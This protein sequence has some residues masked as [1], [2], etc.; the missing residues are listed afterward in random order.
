MKIVVC[1]FSCENRCLRFFIWKSLFAM[2]I[3]VC[4]F[5]CENRCLRFFIWKSLFAISHKT[6]FCEIFT[7]S[8]SHIFL[9]NLQKFWKLFAIF[10]KTLF[11]EMFSVSKFPI[12][13]PS[14]ASEKYLKNS[15]CLQI[16]TEHFPFRLPSLISTHN[17]S[18]QEWT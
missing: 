13:W 2:K 18:G 15:S 8:S 7:I 10:H 11:C 12:F 1:D 5:S 9:C 16:F 4:D 6:R 3:V 17:R 14:V